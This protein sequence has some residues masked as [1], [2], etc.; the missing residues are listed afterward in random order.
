MTTPPAPRGALTPLMVGTLAMLSAFA[1]M[2]ID[3]YLPAF[4]TIQAEFGTSASEVQLSLSAFMMAFGFGQIFYGPLGDYFG[5]RPV[6]LAGVGLYV[7]ASLLCLL[8]Q[9][10]CNSSRC[11]SSRASPP[12]PPR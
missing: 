7:I 12:A 3:M 2:S 11:A 5:R 6:L 10:R 9:A 4:P 8:V 1:P